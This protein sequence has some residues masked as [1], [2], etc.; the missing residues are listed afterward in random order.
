VCDGEEEGSRSESSP[1]YLPVN[2]RKSIGEGR[3]G[4]DRESK[5]DLFSLL[6]LPLPPL[7][8]LSQ[9]D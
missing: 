5:D 7:Y 3:K 6:R 1:V 4:A 9:P 8:S 2:G